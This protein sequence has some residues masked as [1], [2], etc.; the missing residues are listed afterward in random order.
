MSPPRSASVTQRRGWQTVLAVALLCSLLALPLAGSVVGQSDSDTSPPTIAGAERGNTTTIIVT[1]ADDQGVDESS[2]SSSDFRPSTGILRSAAVNESGSNATVRLTLVSTVNADNVT[3]SL[4]GSISDDAGNSIS[5]GSATATGMDAQQPRLQQFTMDRLNETHGEIIVD[6]S[7]PLSQLTLAVGGVNNGNFDIRNV[8]ETIQN[9]GGVQYTRV[10]ELAEEGE[11]NLLL[12]TL[13]DEANNSVS[14]NVQRTYLVDRTPPSV[15]IEGPTHVTVDDTHEFDA[16]AVDNVVI[17][18]IEWTIDPNTT[19]ASPSV[20]H[21]FTEPGNRTITV[22]VTDGRGNT[23]TARHNVTV[24]PG[25]SKDGVEMAPIATNRTNATVYADRTARR[26]RIA[27]ERGQ[28]ASRDGVGVESLTVTPPANESIRTSV[29]VRGQAR[30]FT[31]AT[32]RPSVASFSVDHPLDDTAENV[33]V[34]FAV[35]R[36]RLQAVGLAPDEISLYRLDGNWT[37]LPTRID[38]R[39]NETVHF[40]ADSP[41]LSEFAIGASSASSADEETGSGDETSTTGDGSGGA[42]DAN[43]AE[44]VTSSTES[45]SIAVSSVTLA[46]DTVPAGAYAVVTATVTNQGAQTGSGRITLTANNTTVATRTVTILPGETRTVQ[47][48]SRVDSS[49]EFAVDGTSAGRISV[50]DSTAASDSG[51]TATATATPTDNT[52]ATRTAQGTDSTTPRPDTARATTMQNSTSEDGG[53]LPN[54]LGLL[55]GGIVGTILVGL[56]G[57]VAV[58]LGVLKALALHLGY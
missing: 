3:V 39:E 19:R 4:T 12:M 36:Y 7:E 15:A 22:T 48:A 55:P 17:E 16:S 5:T 56:V 40:R 54:P 52:T 35:D 2:I 44:T 14:Y 21:A 45:A 24:V 34:A 1:V 8:T 50:E 38:W 25:A 29:A 32:G 6:T 30:V 58:S 20:R 27:D 43:T 31:A 9:G 51:D 57:F 10:H 46:D 11:M 41:G 37:E 23:A 28:V 42:G 53:G 13:V 49:V 26:V 33:T 47:F 18:S